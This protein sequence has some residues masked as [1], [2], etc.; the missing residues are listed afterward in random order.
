MAGRR[1]RLMD[2]GG[3]KLRK[4]VNVRLARWQEN[5]RMMWHEWLILFFV[6]CIL[7]ISGCTNKCPRPGNTSGTRH[8]SVHRHT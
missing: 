6:V 8:V 5:C 1:N 2:S 7:M 4:L 3:M